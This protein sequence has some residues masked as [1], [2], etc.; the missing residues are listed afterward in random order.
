LRKPE[1]F[2]CKASDSLLRI[3]AAKAWR[4]ENRGV[5]AFFVCERFGEGFVF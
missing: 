5:P 4:P 1:I 3:V 2:W